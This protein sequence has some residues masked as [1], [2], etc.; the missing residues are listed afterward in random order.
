MPTLP[1]LR[2][3]HLL[4]MTG[5]YFCSV[6][7]MLQFPRYILRM[8]CSA[9]L[10]GWLLAIGLIPALLL[11]RPIGEWNRRL[12]GRWPMVI[13]GLIALAGN[14]PM[15]WLDQFGVAMVVSRIV[16]AIGHSMFF[17]SLFAQAAFMVEHPAQRVKV[18]GWMAV[19]TQVGNAVGGTLGEM[20][21]QHSNA[22]YWWGSAAFGLAATVLGACWSLRPQADID[23]ET[24]A[25]DA[26]LSWSPEIWATVAVA[27]AFAG[28]TQFVPAF[29]DDLVKNGTIEKPF[30]ASWFLTTALLVVAS[31]RLI[32]GYFAQRLLHPRVLLACHFILL[33][34]FVALPWMHTLPVAILLGLAF[35][36]SYGWL[37][38]ALS[39]LAFTN[40][41]SEARGVVSGWLMVAFEIGFRL[42]PIGM[43]ALIAYSG[44]RAMFIGLALAYVVIVAF[45]WSV[46]RRSLQA[47]TVGT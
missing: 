7:F 36:L 26:R 47:A 21:Y 40:V 46:N 43:G 41:P 25:A 14:L 29:I 22:A 32:G 17:G 37:Y 3:A 10:V 31:V 18:I 44:Y 12:G 13:G 38:P 8:G 1:R 4:A 23:A 39:A 24:K 33:A 11:A 15:L 2:L 5:I 9:T 28:A 19:M 20:A 27:M 42:T 16:Y 34:T 6:G 30:A 45:G 35:G